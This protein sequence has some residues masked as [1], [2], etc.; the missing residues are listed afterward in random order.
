LQPDCIVNGT[1]NCGWQHCPASYLYVKP[2]TAVAA[3]GHHSIAVFQACS[4]LTLPTSFLLP[5]PEIINLVNTSMKTCFPEQQQPTNNSSSGS[6]LQEWVT[7]KA[8]CATYLYY[9]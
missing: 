9:M 8:A 6:S 4:S 7:D 5:Q 3:A 1:G 2:Y